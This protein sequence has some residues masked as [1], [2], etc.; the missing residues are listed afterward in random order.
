MGSA[1]LL[2][3]LSSN[4]QEFCFQAAKHS[5]I[6]CAELQGDLFADC[7]EWHFQAAKRFDKSRTILQEGRFA[8]A[9]K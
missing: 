8:D 9:E 6:E 5:Y 3:A 1:V 7:E 2:V 4:V